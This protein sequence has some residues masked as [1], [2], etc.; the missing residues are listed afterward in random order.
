MKKEFDLS[1]F[2]IESQD[3]IQEAKVLFLSDVKE[4]IERLKNK[5]GVQHWDKIDKLAGEDLK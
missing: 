3:T 1:D 5:L 4:F 2:I